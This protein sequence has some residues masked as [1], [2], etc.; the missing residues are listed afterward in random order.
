MRIDK[1]RDD[2]T[3]LQHLPQ[4]WHDGVIESFMEALRGVWF[5]GLGM[6]IIGLI[7]I[8][9]MKQHKLHSNLARV[10]D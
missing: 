9:L 10:E 7:C 1:I 8:S 2:L 5:T 6:A 3:Q 4:G